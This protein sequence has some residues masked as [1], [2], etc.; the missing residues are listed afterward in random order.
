[1]KSANRLDIDSLKT[2]DDKLMVLGHILVSL[3]EKIETLTL[4][5]VGDIEKGE[6]G[7]IRRTESLEQSVSIGK[8]LV[9]LILATVVTAFFNSCQARDAIIA[10]EQHPAVS[11]TVNP[12]GTPR[13]SPTPKPSPTP[14]SGIVELRGEI[15]E[16][17]E[18]NDILQSKVDRLLELL[19]EGNEDEGTDIPG[20][21]DGGIAPG[22]PP[23]G[24]PDI[25]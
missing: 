17:K 2:T 23:P 21:F 20:G 13:P 14:T 16:L 18:R 6:P 11:D 22:S 25:P 3:E 5:M 1:M 10:W 12:T 7:Y 15:E 4:A 8:W 9:A 19:E 24:G